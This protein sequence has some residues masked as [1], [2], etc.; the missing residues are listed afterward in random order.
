MSR[1]ERALLLALGGVHM[2]DADQEAADQ[3]VVRELAWAKWRE[4]HGEAG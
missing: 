1:R 4:L 3:E 2:V